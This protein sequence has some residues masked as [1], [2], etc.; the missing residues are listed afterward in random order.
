MKRSSEGHVG[1][2]LRSIDDDDL[3]VFAYKPADAPGSGM[4]PADFL[5][6]YIVLANPGALAES[7]FVEVKDTDRAVLFPLADIRPAQRL[8]IER[9]RILGL[10][11]WLVIWWRKR[12]RW[13]ISSATALPLEERSVSI[14][15]LASRYG[16]D[17]RND[18][19]ASFLRAALLGDIGR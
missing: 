13:T 16:V 11:Y 6:W 1:E 7:A 5:V 18:E 3:S 12:K 8:A 2:A 10:P 17:C 9:C 4:K 14:V 19:L 15:A